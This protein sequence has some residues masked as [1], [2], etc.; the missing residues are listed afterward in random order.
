LADAAAWLEASLLARALKVGPWVYPLVNLAHLLGVALLL[1]AIAVL[2]LRLVG[3][4]PDAPVA[5]LARATVPVAGAGLALALLTGPAL[6]AVQATDYAANPFLWLKFGA[7][8]VGL[9]NLA[10]LHRSAAWRGGGGGR[11]RFAVAG[12]VSLLAW[13]AAASAGRMIAYW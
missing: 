11:R 9:A 12:G 3:F 8:A 1:G 13:T 6:L 4:W 2:D 7:V 5:P 10:A